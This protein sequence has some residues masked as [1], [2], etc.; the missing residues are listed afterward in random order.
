[1]ENL[2]I[3][4]GGLGTIEEDNDQ[5]QIGYTPGEYCLDNLKDL[6]RFLR[7]DDPET[8]EVFKQVCKWNIVGKDILQIIQYCQNDTT[9]VLNAGICF[10]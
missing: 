1:M 4:C 2:S 3:I 9:L 8:R 7:R 6:L 5:N 10:K